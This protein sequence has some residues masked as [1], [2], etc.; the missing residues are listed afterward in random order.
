M[1]LQRASVTLTMALAAFL[2][3]P[4]ISAAQTAKARATAKVDLEAR[5]KEVM[6]D[7]QLADT[8]Y[9]NG[10]KVAAV[11]SNCHG[12]GGNS[13][14]STVPNLAGQNPA[15][16][17]E[18]VRLFAV[19]K[20]RNEF[21][22][23]IIRA[24]ES[25]EKIGMVL[26]YAAQD[27][28]HKPAANPEIVSKGQALFNSICFKCHGND[29]RGNEQVARIAGQQADYIRLTLK[30]Y[31][32]GSIARPN[33]IMTPNVKQLSNADIEAVVAYVSSMP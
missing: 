13:T 24:M 15:Y 20:R 16:L 25:D 12:E 29:G 14:I 23:G 27:V 3:F 30:G 9:K 21:M 33:S 17:L 6:A 11:C 32:D 18:Q 2:A 5:F 22:E 10:R 4:T 28:T 31:R 8:L 1:L 7:P 19:G 26:F